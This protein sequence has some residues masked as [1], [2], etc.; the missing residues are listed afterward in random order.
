MFNKRSLIFYALLVTSI[1]VWLTTDNISFFI[2][3]IAMIPVQKKSG[4]RI[5][6]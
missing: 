4:F 3:W 1:I 2:L 6:E 5:F